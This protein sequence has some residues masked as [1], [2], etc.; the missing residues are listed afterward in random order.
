MIIHV[1]FGDNDFGMDFLK[2]C[3]QILAELSQGYTG[4][5][6]VDLF[7]KYLDKKGIEDLRQRL[8]VC[9]IGHHIATDGARGRF[10]DDFCKRKAYDSSLGTYDRLFKYLDEIT[11]VHIVDMTDSRWDNG[12]SCFMDVLLNIVDLY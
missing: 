1:R 10:K 11:T 6:Q 12:E 3:K 9:A 2:A 7:K 4:E 5:D 8:L